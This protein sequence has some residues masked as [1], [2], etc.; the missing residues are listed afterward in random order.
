[1]INNNCDDETRLSLKVDEN[2]NVRA[3]EVGSWVLVYQ[4]QSTNAQSERTTAASEYDQITMRFN[5]GINENMR[6]KKTTNKYVFKY[7]YYR[8]ENKKDMKMMMIIPNYVLI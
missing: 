7:S 4:E 6:Q 1:M 5:L 8:G 3:D 2:R